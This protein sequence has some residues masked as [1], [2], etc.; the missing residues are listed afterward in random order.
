MEPPREKSIKIRKEYLDLIR[1]GKKTVE[2]RLGKP[3]YR[4]IQKGDRL[5]FY[6]EENPEDD[7]ICEVERVQSFSSFAEMLKAIGYLKCLPL[8]ASFDSALE[9][10]LSFPGFEKDQSTLGVCAFQ[11][12]VVKSS[13]RL[14]GAIFDNLRLCLFTTMERSDSEPEIESPP[15]TPPRIT[16][17]KEPPNPRS[18]APMA[19]GKSVNRYDL[20]PRRAASQERSNHIPQPPKSILKPATSGATT[21][22]NGTLYSNGFGSSA[23]YKASDQ[24]EIEDR[25]L[26]KSTGQPNVSAQS[27]QGQF[28]RCNINQPQSGVKPEP[29]PSFNGNASHNS[30]TRPTNMHV[31]AMDHGDIVN[32]ILNIQ[33]AYEK[34]RNNLPDEPIQTHHPLPKK[35]R[36][37]SSMRVQNGTIRD[38]STDRGFS[39]NTSDNNT[40]K[41]AP[42]AFKRGRTPLADNS[43]SARGPSS[44]RAVPKTVRGPSATRQLPQQ[45]VHAQQPGRASSKNREI[46]S[47]SARTRTPE[48]QNSMPGTSRDM[49]KQ[50]PSRSQYIAPVRMPLLTETEEKLADQE[51]EL[52]DTVS[53]LERANNKLN[54]QAT[55]SGLQLKEYDEVSALI[56]EYRQ[57]FQ[58][59]DD[60]DDE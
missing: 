19:R 38:R 20:D 44:E 23:R 1:E 17:D 8:H 34:R 21:P 36:G 55:L 48:P 39:K 13:L 51:N 41:S 4:D 7:V 52:H 14:F 59:D 12:K 32:D 60:D 31:P 26:P 3:D 53:K 42:T 43:H 9:T 24:S 6:V 56:G 54:T 22:N 28:S 30:G 47:T 35:S 27:V 57:D 29:R 37:N 45:P 5:R 15:K 16:K 50:R 25:S 10:Y 40:A 58:E 11:I 2:G 46:P 49:H 33:S 18:A